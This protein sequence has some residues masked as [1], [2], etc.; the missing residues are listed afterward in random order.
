MS[1]NYVPPRVAASKLGVS[2]KTL[3][4]WLEAGKIEGIFTQGGQRRYNLDSIIPVRRGNPADERVTVLYARVSSRSQKTEMQQQVNFLKSRYPDAEII[5][6]IG[7]GLNFKRKGLQALLDR[8]LSN[9]I[10]LVVV[11]HKDRLCRFGFDIISWL[12]TRQQT[13]ILVLDQKNLSPEREMVEDILAIVHVFSCRLY[14]LRKYKKQITL[15]SELPSI[16][17]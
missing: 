9:T 4:R 15:D 5:T 13:E 7:S 12:C 8:V 11:A 16:P 1:T 2:T 10:K 6:D 3:E 17:K 14:G